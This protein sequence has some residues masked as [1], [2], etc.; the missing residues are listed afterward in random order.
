[1]QLKYHEKYKSTLG[2][3]KVGILLF[4]KQREIPQMIFQILK[5]KRRIKTSWGNI[6]QERAK[7]FQER[8]CGEGK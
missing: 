6:A 7:K 8:K 2:I 5:L 4:S 1:M 3:R